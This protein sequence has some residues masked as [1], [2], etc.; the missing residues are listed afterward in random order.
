LHPI[1][2]AARL[3][4]RCRRRCSLPPV[5]CPECGAPAPFRGAAI[6]LVCEYC[7]STVVRTG[8][9]VRLIGKV[10]A[11]LDNGSPILLGSKGTFDALPF[12]LVGRLQ[13]RHGRGTWNEWFVN[14]ADGTVGW[15]ADAQGSFSMLRPRDKTIV[16]G[17]VPAFAHLE[18]GKPIVIQGVPHV[19]VERR[20]ADYQGA[21]GVLPFVAE[22]GVE[23]YSAD[24]RGHDGEFVTLDYGEDGDHQRPTLYTGR[25]VDLAGLGLQPLRRFAGWRA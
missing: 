2:V 25:A 13:L 16:A 18:L 21:E 17:K 15:L 1:P 20:A 9:D 14:F 11:L 8:V 6:S 7:G 23:F 3:W 4:H 22:P 5:Q 19:L 24:L 12:E 10:S